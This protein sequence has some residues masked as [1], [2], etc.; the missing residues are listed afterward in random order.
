MRHNE[1]QR[2]NNHDD[3]GVLERLSVLEVFV[4]FQF[5]NIIIS[6]F[7]CVPNK[8]NQISAWETKR[9]KRKTKMTFIGAAVGRRETAENIQKPKRRNGTIS[10]STDKRQTS[11]RKRT[12]RIYGCVD[13]ID[14]QFVTDNFLLSFAHNDLLKLCHLKVSRFYSIHAFA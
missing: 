3:D 2:A 4:A 14:N 7:F 11:E 5:R 6:F 1:V 10:M 12:R 9:P 8:R 13:G